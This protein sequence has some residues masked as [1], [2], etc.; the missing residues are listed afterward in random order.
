[1]TCTVSVLLYTDFPELRSIYV[2]DGSPKI[3][4]GYTNGQIYMYI[5]DVQLISKL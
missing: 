2:P 1:M 4:I 3:G 5:I